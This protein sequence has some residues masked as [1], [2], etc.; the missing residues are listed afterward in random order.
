L[1]FVGVTALLLASL[2][3]DFP[4]SFVILAILIGTNLGVRRLGQPIRLW[5]AALVGSLG[6]ALG[7]SLGGFVYGIKESWSEF[8]TYT[9][10]AIGRAMAQ[11]VGG[12]ALG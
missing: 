11:G 2:R 9:E 8:S 12:S 7:G 5:K 6:G 4:I 10:Y 3:A 1:A